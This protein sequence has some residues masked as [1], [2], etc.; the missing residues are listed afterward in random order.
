MPFRESAGGV[1]ARFCPASRLGRP[2]CGAVES[3]KGLGRRLRSSQARPRRHRSASDPAIDRK[4]RMAHQPTTAFG[5]KNHHYVTL[6]TSRLHDERLKS[7][8]RSQSASLRSFKRAATNGKARSDDFD[9]ER[10]K[11]LPEKCEMKRWF[12]INA[13]CYS[14]G[15][16]KGDEAPRIAI[17]LCTHQ[18]GAFLAEQLDSI[19]KQSYQNWVVHASDDG[20]T[21][22]TLSILESYQRRWPKGRLNLYSGP[23]NGFAANFLSLTCRREIDAH[24]FAYSDQDDIWD[25]NKLDMAIRWLKS[26]PLENAAVYCNRT[27]LVDSKNIEIGFSPLFTKPP[28][29]TNALIQNIGGGN[30]MVFN[31]AARELVCEVGSTVPIVSHDWWLYIL[32]TGCGGVVHYDPSPTLRYRQHTRNAVGMNSSGVA[33]LRRVRMVW[34]G[35]FKSWTD[36]NITSVEAILDKLTPRNRHAFECFKKSRDKRL[37]F[38]LVYFFR[39]K[40]WRQA[41]IENVMI[42]LAVMFR[43]V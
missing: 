27:R 31:N 29:F 7:L 40:V 38:R 32:V 6:R 23:Q 19:Q 1:D 37:P 26:L 41:I 9:L 18:G 5:I 39:S 33:K 22:E 10:S 21:D 28:S 17:L 4:S 34:E 24:F 2:R 30:T 3:P 43:K 11:W 16:M 35:R 13:A 36:R 12:S 20:S 15:E 42:I 14:G 25:I 8:G